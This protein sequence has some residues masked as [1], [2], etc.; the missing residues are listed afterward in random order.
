MKIRKKLILVSKI[1]WDICPSYI[2]LLLLNSI[3]YGGQ[4]IC[5]VI[6]PKYIIDELM[7]GREGDRLILFGSLIVIS[8]VF[9]YF[10]GKTSKRLL[11]VRG[12]LVQM[13]LDR[14]LAEKIM[15]IEY[16]HLEDPYYLDLKERARFAM[17]NQSAVPGLIQSI[18]E[19]LRQGVTLIGLVVIM[20]QLSWI[21]VVV[22]LI[23]IAL[24]LFIQARFA[25][26]QQKFFQDIIPVNRKYGYYVGLCF[27]DLGHKD[28]RLYNMSDMIGNKIIEFDKELVAWF[29]E[30][31]H[32]SAIYMGLYQVINV[33]QV[34]LAY[35]YVGIR[36]IVDFGGG[37][38]SI[39]SLTMYVNSAINFSLAIFEMGTNVVTIN[40][41]LSYLEPFLELMELPEEKEISGSEILKEIDSIRFENVTFSY[42]KTDKK[43]LEDISFEI[44]KGEKISIVGLNGAGKST[45]VKLICRLYKPDSGKIYI[46]NRDIYD[47]E[48][49]SYNSS[50]SAVFQDFKL[51]NFSIEE[52]ITCRA[53]LKDKSLVEKIID[54]V[55]MTEK[56]KSLPKG[57]QSLF[58]KAYDSEGIEMS[59]GQSQ[60]IAI[61]R[62]LYKNGSL[63]ILD[64][65]TSALDPIAEAEIYESFNKLVGEKTAIYI[66]HRMSSSVFCDKILVINKGRI[67]D[68]DSHENLMKKEESTYQKLFQSQAVN[69]SL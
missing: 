36:C 56:I 26:Y 45:I 61:A 62:A 47:Y 65:P 4:I 49:D 55:G 3:S 46:N 38:I 67:E 24:M 32:K 64:E 29:T 54:E 59:G 19:I 39:G 27:A 21:L 51:F 6:L 35:G 17:T 23:T 57:L 15:N 5:N 22:L 14:V 69:Y 48:Y 7:G 50:M 53:A 42:P 66:S 10:L 33:L 58:G 34:V 52:N 11:D 8:N 20:L 41:M 16:S 12:Q 18:T 63:I 37:L 9:W 68:F 44:K 1:T 31:R 13:S 40:Q 60:K 25:K 43:V 2:F 28:I 30:Y